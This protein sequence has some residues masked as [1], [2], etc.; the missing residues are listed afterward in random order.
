MTKTIQIEPQLEST[1][2]LREASRCL[3]CFD[4][5]CAKACPAGIVI[6]RFIRMIRSGNVHGAAEVVRSANPMALS[7]GIACPDEQLC[8][9]ACLRAAIDSPVSIRRLHRFANDHEEDAGPRAPAIAPRTRSRV[10]VVGGGPSGLACAFELRRRG[11]AV[12][13]YEGRDRV[14]GVLSSTIPL[15]RFPE[16]VIQRD[17]AWTLG[18]ERKKGRVAGGQ[19]DGAAA[20]V[21]VGTPVA[22]VEALARTYDAVFVAPGLVMQD[23]EIPGSDLR[24]VT[25]AAGFLGRCR[26]SRYATKVGK[27]IVVI[28]GG[29]V[30]VDAAM[31]AV[32]CGEVAGG[33]AP[34][35][36]ILYR[37]GRV[38]MPAWEREV[39][40]AER[41]G[42]FLHV[43]AIPVAFE[44]AK[45]R[46][47]EVHVCRAALGPEDESGRRS[48]IPIPGSIYV[49]PCDTAILATGMRLDRIPLGKLPIT[50][51]GLIKTDGATR[52]VRGN[53]FAGGDVANAAQTIVAAV[54]DGKLAA[55]A[56]VE[57]LGAGRGSR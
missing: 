34:R 23:S 49:M 27:D 21:K 18:V 9:A 55:T 16:S 19:K 15:Y 2:A 5:P 43:L 20:N 8:A 45:G 13:L 38:E 48:P 39:S 29:N 53:I 10:A 56:I 33:P 1:Q 22:D 17:A 25:D 32:R 51:E 31:A 44:G 47:T 57:F 37:R 46:L 30:A 4:A 52:R 3:Q 50:R 41:V 7:C 54:R 12:T 26:K 28:G 24:G 14:G 36:H 11:I 40:E 42:V 35:V 6:P